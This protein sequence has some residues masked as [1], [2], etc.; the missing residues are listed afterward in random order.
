MIKTKFFLKKF[1]IFVIPIH[2]ILSLSNWVPYPP[3]PELYNVNNKANSVLLTCYPFPSKAVFHSF[4]ISDATR[5]EGWGGYQRKVCLK[6]MKLPGTWMGPS[7][8]VLA[9]SYTWH[10]QFIWSYKTQLCSWV[11]HIVIHKW[12]CSTTFIHILGIRQCI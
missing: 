1:I 10:L 4:W 7:N 3:F 6:V 12:Y 8:F 5:G 11:A 2:F 9:V